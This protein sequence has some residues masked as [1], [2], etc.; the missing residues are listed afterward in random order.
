[1]HG[2]KG[3]AKWSRIVRTIGCL[4]TV[5]SF[6]VA[7]GAGFAAGPQSEQCQKIVLTG[8]V[9]EGAEWRAQLGEGWIF[10]V[11]P[12][13]PSSAGSG[14]DLVVDREQPAGYPDAILLATPPYNSINEREVGTTYGLRAQ[15][16]IGWNPR[17]FRFLTGTKA[18]AEGQR[19]YLALLRDG[20][21][22][23]DDAVMRKLMDLAQRSATGQ[24]RILDARL[25][26]GV[27]DAEPFAEEWAVQSARTQHTIQP[28]L[29][30]K[31]TPQGE[32]YWIRFSITLW[33]PQTWKA[34]KELGA[35]RAACSE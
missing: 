16:A 25:A 7:P 19:L 2:L 4:V 27:A 22:K 13:E 35:V 33:L 20:K 29:K 26:P 6:V 18:F 8:D 30:G 11:K 34:P 31:A 1:M 12:I 10:R 5:G 15:D 23:A 28:P 24:F 14:W 17:S 9:N 32:L 21:A 3:Y